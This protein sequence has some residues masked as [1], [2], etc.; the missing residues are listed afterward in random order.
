[1]RVLHR[2]QRQ[3]V[4][5]V[6]P[7]PGSNDARASRALRQPA[8][9]GLLASERTRRRDEARRRLLLYEELL[10]IQ[11]NH[12]DEDGARA[13]PRGSENKTSQF[14]ACLP[15]RQACGRGRVE[16]AALRHESS[17]QTGAHRP[18]VPFANSRKRR[19][20]PLR[21][22]S[23]SR[24]H[25][26]GKPRLTPK[27]WGGGRVGEV[28]AHTRR[29]GGLIGCCGLGTGERNA[30]GLEGDVPNRRAERLEARTAL[31]TALL[32]VVGDTASLVAFNLRRASL[33]VPRDRRSPRWRASR[34]MSAAS[35]RRSLRR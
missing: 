15:V 34:S 17:L 10:V 20:R 9:G 7:R 12:P 4:L 25:G 28:S 3:R 26:R 24:Q 19:R 14:W 13:G 27:G 18:C 23:S 32:G 30:D 16:S 29:R 5:R 31:L 22:G 2:P 35:P 21:P 6:I 1:M 11:V 8:D 33:R